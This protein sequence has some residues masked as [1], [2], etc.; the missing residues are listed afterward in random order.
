MV[1]MMETLLVVFNMLS[2]LVLSKKR[3]IIIGLKEAV[4]FL[5]IKI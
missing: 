1:A 5:A 2:M 3:T 4:L